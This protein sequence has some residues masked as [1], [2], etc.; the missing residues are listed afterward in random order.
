MIEFINIDIYLNCIVVAAGVSVKEFDKLYYDNVTKFTNEEYEEIRRDIANE[1]SC[2]GETVLLENGN[3]FVFIR[4]G[5]ER[6]ELYV[7]H[8]LFHAVNK[9]LCRAGVNHDADAEPWA[10]LMGWLVNEYF[11][12][13]DDFEN[14]NK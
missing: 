4:K 1:N 7:I 6:E 11:N 2:N 14:K 12:R 5:H 10:Y 9:L 13:L 8:E 3:I